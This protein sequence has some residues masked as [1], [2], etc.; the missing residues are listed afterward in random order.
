MVTTVT[1]FTDCFLRGRLHVAILLQV[2]PTSPPPPTGRLR[3]ALVKLFPWPTSSLLDIEESL[4]SS[5]RLATLNCWTQILLARSLKV[6]HVEV[7]WDQ[8]MSFLFYL[9]LLSS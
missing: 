4:W 5:I 3:V 8:G 1:N 2:D 9:N 7:L 6:F